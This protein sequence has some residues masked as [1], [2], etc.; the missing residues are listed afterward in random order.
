MAVVAIFTGIIAGFFVSLVKSESHA[1]AREF[2]TEL[3]RL[4]EMDHEELV[5]ISERAK[6]ILSENRE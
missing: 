1:V 5:E 3:K 2:L 6:R 4:P